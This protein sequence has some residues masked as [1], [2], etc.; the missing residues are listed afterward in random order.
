MLPLLAQM[1]AQPVW[2]VAAVV[3]KTVTSGNHLMCSLQPGIIPCY[4]QGASSPD[5]WFEICRVQQM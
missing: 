2:A 4:S 1:Q 5:E 3:L